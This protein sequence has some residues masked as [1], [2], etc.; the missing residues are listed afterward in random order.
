M[1]GV[2]RVSRII[3]PRSLETRQNSRW[4]LG[5]TLL[6]SLEGILLVSSRCRANLASSR[7]ACAALRWHLLSRACQRR[8]FFFFFLRFLCAAAAAAAGPQRLVPG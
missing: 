2:N 4:L 1:F 7:E 6:E 5:P 3:V 8:F